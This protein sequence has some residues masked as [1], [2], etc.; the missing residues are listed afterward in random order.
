MTI[1][2]SDAE[3][4]ADLLERAG[5]AMRSSRLRRGCCAHLPRRG[6]L[7]VTGDLHDHPVHYERIEHFARLGRPDHHVVLHELIHG[8]RLVNGVDLSHRM[9]A[10]VAALV[11]AH[12]EHVHPVLA[13]HELAQAFRQGVSKGA[14]DN[15]AL[16]DAGLEWAFGDDA[17]FV[18]EALES[19]V[20]AMPLAVRC[21]NGCM[22]SHSLPSPIAMKRFDLGVLD[23]ALEER[24]YL[25]NTGSAWLMVWG[26][27]QT[28]EQIE[29]LA[30]A[31]SVR[32]FLT[33]HAHV[34]S[35]VE[36][37]DERLVILNSDHEQ[38]M[39]LPL[40]LAA[41][42]MSAEEQLFHAIP[43]ASLGSIP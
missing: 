29:A 4:V 38:A 2:L 42:P 8:D 33:G 23:R 11:I 22:I 3:A 24:D 28:H 18:A 5:E 7:L 13:N 20:R 39:V 1:D 27:G 41:D 34:P 9:L 12:P 10:R 43:I 15:V 32:L 6:R 17:E 26:R 19:F 16:F 31:W 35:G 21:D 36:V 40:D 30:Q 37:A 25:A 14:G